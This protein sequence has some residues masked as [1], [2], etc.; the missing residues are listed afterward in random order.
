MPKP[1]AYEAMLNA[2][3]NQTKLSI[4]FLLSHHEKMTVT[5]M[6]KQVKVGKANLYHFVSQMVSDGMLTKPEAVVRGNYVEKYY[7]LNERLFESIETDKQRS[8][9]KQAS[10]KELQ[11]ILQSGLAALGLD[12]RVLA[13]EVAKAD[14]AILEQIAQFVSVERI[15]ISYSILPDQA[16]DYF[17]GEFRRVYKTIE[18]KW[19][20]EKAFPKGNRVVVVAL[21]RF[22]E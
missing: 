13:E 8:R 20:K 22:K 2:I 12:L 19:G 9:L 6:A 18:E 1:D 11:T 16:Y 5:Q 7:R 14:R 15:T 21:P 10:P 4:V 17:V 3:S